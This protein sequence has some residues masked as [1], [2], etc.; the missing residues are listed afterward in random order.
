MKLLT[1]PCADCQQ[2]GSLYYPEHDSYMC[3]KY[4]AKVSLWS[5]SRAHLLNLL[6]PTLEAWRDHWLERGL[7]QRNLEGTFDNLESDLIDIVRSE[8]E[9]AK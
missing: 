5:E 6:A 3:A 2:L 8:T 1:G 4:A 9:V 7:D